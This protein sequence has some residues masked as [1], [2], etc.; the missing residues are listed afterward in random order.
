MEALAAKI[1]ESRDWAKMVGIG[2]HPM[3]GEYVITGP[4]VGNLH[5]QMSWCKYFGYVVQIRKK[6]GEFC[7]DIVLIRHPNGELGRHENQCYFRVD[8]ELEER[9]KALF[10]PGMTPDE[11]E[12]YSK[13]YTLGK[14]YP[15]IG[16]IIEANDAGPSVS[17][18]PLMKIT[19]S[20][21][22]G[23]QSVEIV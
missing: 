16:K 23:I 2:K 9:I 21:P 17:N 8:A 18:R 12:D 6:A 15:E 22:D 13:P 11:C 3:P 1:V 5:G 4:Q 19:V 20:N 10:P 7:S 14:E